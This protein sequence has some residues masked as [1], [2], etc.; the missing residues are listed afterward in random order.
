MPRARLLIAF[1]LSGAAGLIYELG[2][3]RMFS[4]VMGS[5]THSFEIMLSA[6]ILGL[7]IGAWSI[8]RAADRATRP[9]AFLG[10]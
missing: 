9:V 1:R 2:W 6:F 10:G 8:R 7:A 4:L 5:T 3:I